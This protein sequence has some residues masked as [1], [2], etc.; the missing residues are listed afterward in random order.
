VPQSVTAADSAAVATTT[1]GKAPLEIAHV[2]FT[3]I[4]AYSML[5]MD[6]QQERLRDLQ[7]AV[8]QTPEF[9]RAERDDQLIRL[10]TGDGMAL[11]FFG[12]PKAPVQ[13]ALELSREL[14]QH[15]EIRLR[16][17]IHS[18]PVYR[19]ADINANR[20][21]AGGGINMAQRVMDCGDAGHILLSKAVAD[22][23]S[24]LSNWRGSLKDL[25]EAEVKHRVRVHVF[26][27]CT[28]EIG[29][30]A[31]PT[32]LRKATAHKTAKWSLAVGAVLLLA[33][34]AGVEW[35]FASGRGK[36]ITGMTRRR[37]IAVLGF[38]NITQRKE[39]DWIS[40]TLSEQLPTELAAGEKVRIV[41][42]EQIERAKNDL[43]VAHLESV[44]SDVFSAL[45]KRFDSD[46]IVVGSFVN[47][48]GEIRVD[49]RAQ[50]ATTRETVASVA[51]TG[52]PEEIVSLVTRAGVDLREKLGLGDMSATE[53]AQANASRPSNP[54][55]ARFYSEGVTQLRQFN[56]LDARKLLE[57]ATDADPNYAMAY[58]ALA[59]AWDRL[60]YDS[61]RLQAAKSAFE[62]SPKL[63]R[64]ERLSIEA[65]YRV[66][67]SELDKAVEIYRALWT[68]FP[69]ELDYGLRLAAV[70]S[71][72][73]KGQD[74]LAT[75]QAMRRI[76]GPT[77]DDPR[78]DLAAVEAFETLSDYKQEIEAA[79][80]AIE[81]ANRLGQ[82][83][84][85]AEAEWRRC[86]GLD[87]LGQYA[88]ARSAGERAE[89]AYAA[90]NYYLGVARSL[91][92]IGNVLS[93]QGNLAAAR[94]PREDALK[95]AREVGSQRDIAGALNN[96]ANLLSTTGDPE[97]AIKNYREALAVSKDIG[98]VAGIALFENNL[99]TIYLSQGKFDAG[100]RMFELSETTGQQAGDMGRVVQ[101]LT[102]ISFVKVLA[103]DLDGAQKNIEDSIALARQQGMQSYAA[104]SIQGLGDVLFARGDLGGA[105]KNYKDA[106][107]MRSK[108]GE[109]SG[110]ASSRVSIAK[111]ALE[112][113]KPGEAATLAKQAAE[114]FASEKDPDNET[115]AHDIVAQALIKQGKFSDAQAEIQQA[116]KLPS[117]DRTI[118]LSLEV[119]SARVMTKSGDFAGSAKK[120]NDALAEA[121]AIKAVP[122]LF[123]ARL[124]KGE[125]QLASH[126]PEQARATLRSLQSDASKRGFQ[127]LARKADKLL[128]EEP[129]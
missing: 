9:I 25:G 40:D 66:A 100:R 72:A 99:G 105:E 127:L 18:G 62:L 115:L 111:V 49:I 76:A 60:G 88:D 23:L 106:L 13:C 21:V 11:V 91:T 26:N 98:D 46:L 123:Q 35:Y 71:F 14:R 104:A 6:Q 80:V 7:D 81:K 69:D 126:R 30:P 51:E 38:K 93:D 118:R 31:V 57:K 27:L 12:D 58:S 50:D 75:V 3:D 67:N 47:V 103:G 95:F 43:P 19:I 109:K 114:E 34:V 32:K 29:N 22:V 54:Q 90:A 86:I 44:G 124:A 108:L 110:I 112:A 61:K 117:G 48:D 102:N 78:I 36:I 20:N 120:A 42:T 119:T 73:S 52:R 59:A 74:A 5:P 16:M 107:E 82:H 89:A 77:R 1:Q 68:F 53:A 2:L 125:L 41:P 15:P 92:C 79:A 64:E 8:R 39:D 113:E 128:R 10:P 129:R 45:R 83:F 17:G 85:V 96:L 37:S 116:Q 24:Q 63:A 70:Q 28:T 94:K 122:I 101:A 65:Q 97:G 4:V 33:L 56:A 84:L 55:A 87:N 121:N